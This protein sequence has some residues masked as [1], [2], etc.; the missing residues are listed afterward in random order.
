MVLAP[1]EQS[2]KLTYAIN[3]TFQL[4][5]VVRLGLKIIYVG[6]NYLSLTSELT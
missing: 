4:I 2:E 5:Q 6:S 1:S 3:P